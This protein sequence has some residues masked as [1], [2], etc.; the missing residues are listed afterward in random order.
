MRYKPPVGSKL[1]RFV[2]KNANDNIFSEILHHNVTCNI[3]RKRRSAFFTLKIIT[4]ENICFHT[5]KLT[6]CGILKKENYFL[7]LF[8]VRIKDHLLQLGCLQQ[9]L[10]TAATS[11]PPLCKWYTETYMRTPWSF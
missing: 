4:V 9:R 7:C 1:L 5:V 10:A 11:L 6:D 3:S 8:W 2:H